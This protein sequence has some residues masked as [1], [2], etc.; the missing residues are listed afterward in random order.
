MPTRHNT[1]IIGV[2]V[3]RGI[4]VGTANVIP[5]VSGGTMAVIT[6]VFERLVNCIKSFNIDNFKLLF[7]GNLREFANKVELRFVSSIGFGMLV[8]I[9]T[10]ARLFTYL[11]DAYPVFVWAFFFGLIAPSIY[12]VGKTI[13]KWNPATVGFLVVGTLFAV[14]LLLLSPASENGDIAYLVLC[15]AASIS[16]MVLPGVSGSFVLILMGNY[17]LIVLRSISEFN[18]AVLV[19]FA[20]G[21]GIGLI[22]FA[23][24][25]S[26]VMNRFRNQTIA[27]LT[28]FVTG[29]LVFIWPWKNAVYVLDSKGEI[30]VR[31][32][33]AVVQ[34]YQ[35]ILPSIDTVFFIALA[36]AI[37][38]ALSVI[39][40]ETI[41]NRAK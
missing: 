13:D 40:L 36:L 6:G 25:I 19:P 16:A 15:G 17:Q 32:G 35:Y 1:A 2:D 31:K 12:Y 7:G 8:A 29:S 37:V 14:S 26:F 11:F 23:R 41:S 24:L 10:I 9:F 21:C 34:K 30:V 27:C 18:L 3:L 22:I 38:G 5:G 20:A 39:L 4:A 33:A 28:G